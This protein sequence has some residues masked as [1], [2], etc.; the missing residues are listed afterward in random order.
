MLLELL[1]KYK[2]ITNNYESLNPYTNKSGKQI[3]HY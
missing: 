1:I 2:Q 3:K